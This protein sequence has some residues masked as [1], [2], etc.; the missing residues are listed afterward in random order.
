MRACVP[1][2]VRALSMASKK[3]MVCARY[4]VPITATPQHVDVFAASNAIG[5]NGRRLLD[6]EYLLFRRSLLES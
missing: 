2:T 4:D 5:D 6:Y 3:M 1:Y